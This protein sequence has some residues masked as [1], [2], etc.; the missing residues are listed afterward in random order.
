MSWIAVWIPFGPGE[1]D[2][3]SKDIAYYSL[4]IQKFPTLYNKIIVYPRCTFQI[5]VLFYRVVQIYDKN[6]I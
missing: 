5:I 4:L 3:M 6:L 2:D 1:G